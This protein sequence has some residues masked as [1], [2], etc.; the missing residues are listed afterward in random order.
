MRPVTIEAVRASI[1]IK[2]ISTFERAALVPLTLAYRGVRSP[3]R[4]IGSPYGPLL[5]VE[6]S[7][8]GLGHFIVRVPGCP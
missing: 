2:G 5:I 4:A 1:A 8:G 3:Y 7:A 6:L